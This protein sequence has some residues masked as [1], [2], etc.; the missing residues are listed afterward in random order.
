MKV[1]GG[2]EMTLYKGRNYKQIDDL[3]VETT[4]WISTSLLSA[5]TSISQPGP[6]RLDNPNRKATRVMFWI[7]LYS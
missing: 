6:K 5:I 2:I 1:N 4:G 3:L 7:R